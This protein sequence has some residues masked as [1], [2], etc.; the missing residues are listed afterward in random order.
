MKATKLIV[1]VVLFFIIANPL[2]Y[3]LTG[4]LPVLGPMIADKTSGRPTQLGVALHALVYAVT[5]HLVWR[6]VYNK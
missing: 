3:K 2:M 6:L 4:S 1:P 5:A